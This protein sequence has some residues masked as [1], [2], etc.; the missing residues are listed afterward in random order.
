MNYNEFEQ[1]QAK[2]KSL[3]AIAKAKDLFNDMSIQ[4]EKYEKLSELALR[5]YV[6]TL[7]HELNYF[8]YFFRFPAAKEYFYVGDKVDKRTAEYKGNKLM[9][10]QLE[11]FL[12]K[13][14]ETDLKITGFS[15][16]GYEGYLYEIKFETKNKTTF[17]FQIPNPQ[18][19]SIRNIEYVHEGK[20][21][22]GKWRNES[23]LDIFEMSYNIEDLVKAFKE[24]TNETT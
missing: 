1:E 7:K 2:F 10:K 8:D 19:I 4:K 12:S 14:F 17:S 3:M 18:E 15:T 24:I 16:H 13:T 21:A 5:D 6:E 23:S 11:E 9:F 20:L 22:I